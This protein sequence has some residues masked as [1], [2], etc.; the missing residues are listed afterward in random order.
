MSTGISTEYPMRRW[1]FEDAAGRYDIDLGDS[2]VQCRRLASLAVPADIELNYGMDRGT[3]RLRE[4]IA[5]QY[6]DRVDSVTVTH[7]AQEALYLLYNVLLRPGDQVITFRP[8][9]P[10]SWAVPAL[11]SAQ[12]D[13]LDLSGDFTIDVDAV[14]AAARPNL[15]LVVVNTP[16]NPTGRRAGQHELA[17]LADLV[18]GTGGYLLLDEEYSLDLAS[19]AAVG[20]ERVLS[21]SSLSKVYGLPGLRV[22]W[23]YGP[24]AVVAACAERKHLTSISNSVLCEALACE[25]LADRQFYAAEY[26][27]LTGGGLRLLR[28]WVARH[29]GKLHLLPPEGTPFAWLQLTTGE[30]A[31]S[32][33]RRVLDAG[34]LLMPAETLG[35]QGG[36]R[37]CFAREQRELAEGL[38]RIDAVLQSVPVDR[39]PPT[40]MSPNHGPGRMEYVSR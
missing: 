32:F 25:V 1:V 34:V 15:R 24:P 14:R 12:V 16:C 27:R 39:D 37:L 20:N 30:S 2:N 19:S 36:V 35:G 10:Q 31:L 3:Q 28:D 8:G 17:A 11:L 7:G 22:G 21:V 38:R 5:E 23:L 9:W 6:G 18:G 13:V 29:P 40:T 4:L 26:H 33:C